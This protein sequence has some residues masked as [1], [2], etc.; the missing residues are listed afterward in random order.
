MINK[1]TIRTTQYKTDTQIIIKWHLEART[2]E[3]YCTL[4]MFHGS[5]KVRIH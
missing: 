3:P 5:P 4:N 2:C 1:Q